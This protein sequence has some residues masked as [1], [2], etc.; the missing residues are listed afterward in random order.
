MKLYGYVRISTQKQNIERQIRNIKYAYPEATIVQDEYTGTKMTRPSWDKLMK[1]VK[2]GDI[3]I[4]DSV[5]RMSRNAEDGFKV[6][7]ELYNRGI[8][9]V[10]IKEPQINTSTYKGAIKSSIQL[11]G[12]AV[13]T[14]LKG[15]NEYLL[16]LAKEQIRLAFLQAEKE[17]QDLHQR[18]KEGIETARLEGKQIGQKSGIK[19]VTK[20]SLMAKDIIKTH[21]K[22]F[23]GTLSDAEC[24]KLA[25]ISRNSYYKYKLELKR[26]GY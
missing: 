8:E 20:K 10:F 22:D 26:E 3:I 23:G 1:I 19:L 14:I 21:S 25:S 6:Y 2:N 7:E 5:S 11:T 17:V 24:Q 12:T 16:I 4:F 9:L 15:I 18:T 13:D